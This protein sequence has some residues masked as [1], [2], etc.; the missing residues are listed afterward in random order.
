M[1]GR[2]ESSSK[3]PPIGNASRQQAAKNLLLLG[4]ILFHSTKFCL[5]FRSSNFLSRFHFRR[6]ITG[7][8]S[9]GDA[10]SLICSEAAGTAGTS[11]AETRVR[12]NIEMLI[13]WL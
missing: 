5:R 8:R 13:N 7:H 10:A 9:G 1:A 11:G 4:M 12:T 3:V 2:C 6:D